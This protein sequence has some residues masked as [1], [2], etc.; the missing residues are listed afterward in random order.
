MA[1][2]IWE[3]ASDLSSISLKM[4]PLIIAAQP[5]SGLETTPALHLVTG[6]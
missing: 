6:R 3:G 5:Q 2:D 4:Q 1:S